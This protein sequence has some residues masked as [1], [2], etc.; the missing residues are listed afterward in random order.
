M[1]KSS[2]YNNWLRRIDAHMRDSVL[3]SHLDRQTVFS[4]LS[5]KVSRTYALSDLIANAVEREDEHFVCRGC[6][7]VR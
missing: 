2:I 7:F 4:D 5:W 1:H 6:S 3:R